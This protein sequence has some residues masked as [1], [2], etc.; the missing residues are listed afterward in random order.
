MLLLDVW[1]KTKDAASVYYDVTWM[2]Y[3]GAKVP[4]KYAKV[5]G[6]LRDAR[7]KLSI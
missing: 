1:G 5:F 3:V 2:G 4:E 7:T 6:V